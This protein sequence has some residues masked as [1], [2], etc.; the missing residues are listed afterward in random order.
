MI[1]VRINREENTIF[2]TKNEK[3]DSLILLDTKYTGGEIMSEFDK[4]VDVFF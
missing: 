2:L 1:S 3:S 4:I